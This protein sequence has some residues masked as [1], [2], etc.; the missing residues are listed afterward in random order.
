MYQPDNSVPDKL[1][2][3]QSCTACGKL[4]TTSCT[5]ACRIGWAAAAMQR[6]I[7]VRYYATMA[8]CKGVVNWMDTAVL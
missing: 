5:P 1:V 7:K 3:H 2:D 6:I 8:A 4:Q